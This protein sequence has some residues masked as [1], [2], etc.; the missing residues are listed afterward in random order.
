MSS[1]VPPTKCSAARRTV[2]ATIGLLSSMIAG[3]WS[4]QSWASDAA[5][6][7]PDQQMPEI[8]VTAQKRTE[9]AQDI[10]MSLSVISEDDINRTG[11]RDFTDL[12]L[13][14]PGVSYADSRLGLSNFSI[15]GIS[16]TAANP[17]VGSTSTTSLW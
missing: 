11:A 15:R 3:T 1:T 7:L 4:G 10:P 12:L 17:T 14:V 16:T 5:A 2:L 8:L 9:R 13:S 6:N